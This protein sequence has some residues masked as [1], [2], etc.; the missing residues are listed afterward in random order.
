[1]TCKARDGY[2]N[3][4]KIIVQN[5]GLF[6][7][8]LGPLWKV[9]VTIH[10]QFVSRIFGMIYAKSTSFMV[11]FCM[12]FMQNVCISVLKAL[13]VTMSGAAVNSNK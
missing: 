3:T 8:S 1:M 7:F 2:W 13:L 6:S 11:P 5:F 12:T 4:N 10:S 9:S